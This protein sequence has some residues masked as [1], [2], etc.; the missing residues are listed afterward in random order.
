[1][2]FTIFILIDHGHGSRLKSTEY[3]WIVSDAIY[4]WF[5]NFRNGTDKKD[6]LKGPNVRCTHHL[7]ISQHIKY[8][9]MNL[10]LSALVFQTF[11]V[12]WVVA[13][14]HTVYSVH[15]GLH[16]ERNRIS[17]PL[18]ILQETST[19]WFQNHRQQSASSHIAIFK[20]VKW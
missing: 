8:L 19:R 9:I 10:L 16:V 7:G 4:R 3:D 20:T 5:S 18:F 15:S 17:I 6:N 13:F 12:E 11:S 1:M 2:I 14:C